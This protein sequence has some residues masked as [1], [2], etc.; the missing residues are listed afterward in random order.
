MIP[1]LVRINHMRN[2]VLC[3]RPSF[4]PRD[5]V[6]GPVPNSGHLVPLPSSGVRLAGT[7]G[8]GGGGGW[9]GGGGGV[10]QGPPNT[11]FVVN[12]VRADITYLK[13]D[14]SIL[15]PEP[16]HGRL[17]PEEQRYDYMVRWRALSKQEQALWQGRFKDLRPPA[18]Q[19]ESLLYALRELTGENPGPTAEDWKRHYSPVTGKRFQKPLEPREQML[20][21][22]DSLVAA[23]PAR[24]MELLQEFRDRSGPA[25]DQAIALAVP[26]LAT[27]PQRLARRVLAK[28]LHTVPLGVLREKLRDP[29]RETRRAALAACRQRD[30]KALA[31]ELIPLLEDEE[32]ETAKQAH[33]FLRQIALKD[34]GPPRGADADQRR[35]AIA[36][37]RAWWEERQRAAAGQKRSEP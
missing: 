33:K 23:A 2:C 9:G 8:G 34:F 4:S 28:R 15:Q 6:R 37:W 12:F 31:P 26:R 30:E 22:A 20:H 13:Q 36:A 3:H 35:E 11:A 32:P 19:C 17:W 16:N 27:E 7:A 1:E 10:V 29:D 14:F 18:P 24:Q 21:L 25:Y 5:P